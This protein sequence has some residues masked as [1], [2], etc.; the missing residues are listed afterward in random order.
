MRIRSPRG[1]KQSVHLGVSAKP[2][3]SAVLLLHEVAPENTRWQGS[4][5]SGPHQIRTKVAKRNGG[6]SLA[7]H[8]R[9]VGLA[10]E[11]SIG[12][13]PVTRRLDPSHSGRGT[14]SRKHGK[15]FCRLG[16]PEEDSGPGLI[17]TETQARRLMRMCPR[18]THGR[19]HFYFHSR[20]KDAFASAGP[21]RAKMVEQGRAAVFLPQAIKTFRAPQNA[22]RIL[23]GGVESGSRAQTVTCNAQEELATRQTPFTSKCTRCWMTHPRA[24]LR[25]AAPDWILRT[26]KSLKHR[27]L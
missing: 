24:R 5:V 17:S 20:R 9:A 15:A 4:R 10:L 3:S 16:Q 8:L 19:H 13:K 23:F 7:L 22:T 11:S 18:R 25:V 26:G 14:A 1:I 6:N 21:E 12:E 2:V 27:R